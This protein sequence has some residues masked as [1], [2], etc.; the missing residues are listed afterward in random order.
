MPKSAIITLIIGIFLLAN[1]LWIPVKAE[2]AQVLL[3]QAWAA[4][5][6]NNS[7]EK[8]WSWADVTAVG[9][10]TV[11]TRQVD[12]VILSGMSGQSLAFGPGH[13]SDTA[14]PGVSGIIMLG[15]HRDTHFS[16]L[17]HM[18]VGDSVALEGRT[19]TKRYS[20]RETFVIDTR[21]E[22]LHNQSGD[23]LLLVTCYPFDGAIPSTPFRYVVMAENV[24]N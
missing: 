23:I 12:Q 19:D 14:L 10:L 13:N 2:V 18:R 4:S 15:G 8:P 22:T 9:K 24:S 3:S 16:F 5:K 17:Q 11:P 7:F 21:S 20:V 6:A 1:G